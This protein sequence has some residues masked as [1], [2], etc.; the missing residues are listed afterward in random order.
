[1][2]KEEDAFGMFRARVKE[3]EDAPPLPWKKV[4]QEC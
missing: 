4:R 2:K 1:V 3:K